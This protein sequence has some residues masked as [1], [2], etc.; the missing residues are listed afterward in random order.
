[1]ENV[2]NFLANMLEK[3][4]AKGTYTLQE[5]AGVF[6]ALSQLQTAL[7]SKTVEEGKEPASNEEEVKEPSNLKK[8]Q[9]STK[10]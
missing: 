9:K 5:S 7:F 3:A 2:F 4:N 10:S 1:M 6:Q 8:V